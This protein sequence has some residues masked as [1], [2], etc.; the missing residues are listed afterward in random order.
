MC[1]IVGFV[2]QNCMQDLYQGLK[3]LEYRGYDSVGVAYITPNGIEVKKRKGRVE[4][5]RHAILGKSASVAMGHTRWA[6]HGAPSHANA[7]PHAAGQFAV[8]HN[9]IIANYAALRAQL[10]QQGER[11]LSHTDTEVIVRLIAR[12]G[13]DCRT[14]DEVLTAI[15]RATALLTGSWAVALLCAATPQCVYLFKKS[16]PLIV[17]KGQ[18]F[19]CFASDTPALVRYTADVYKMEDDEVAVLTQAEAR[20]WRGETP[21]MPCFSPTTL[22]SSQ[23]DKG[24]YDTYMAKEMAEIPA[25]MRATQ[26]AMESVEL[27]DAIAQAEKLVFVGCG[28][29]YHACLYAADLL[30]DKGDACIAS[31]FENYPLRQGCCVVAVSQ[32]GETADTLQAALQAKQKGAYVVAVTN[33][34]HSGLTHLAHYTLHTL[35]GAEIAVAATK[36]YNAQ[37]VAL[38]RLAAAMGAVPVKVSWVAAKVVADKLSDLDDCAGKRYDNVVLLGRGR[39]YHTCLEGCLKIKEIAYCRCETGYS[40]EIKHGPLAC[41]TRRSLVVLVCTDPAYQAKN[42]NA[43]HEVQTRGAKTLVISSCPDLLPFGTYYFSLPTAPSSQ[44][45]AYAVQPLQYLAYRMAKMRRLDPDKPRHLAK[46]VTVE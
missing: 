22:L 45:A 42:K 6:T 27:P 13:A 10:E 41:V 3:T 19:Y 46:S 17:G 30:G 14:P 25:V 24:S 28:T 15:R 21:I 4:G 7:H 16:N 11:F 32:S 20:F 38:H 23:V 39:D 40:G 44:Q 1:G 43:L 2:K 5:L 9:G 18:D 35:A 29:A 36:S 12:F 26:C 33:V 34:P 31:E 37:L 8:V